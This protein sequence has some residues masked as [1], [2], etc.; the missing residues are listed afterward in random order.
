MMDRGF[1]LAFGVLLTVILAA[2]CVDTSPLPYTPNAKDASSDVTALDGS[3]ERICE[4]CIEQEPTCSYSNC[5]ANP[6][7]LAF[8]QC[9]MDLGC[10]VYPDLQPDRLDCGQPCLQKAGILDYTNPVVGLYLP[11]NACTS[12]GNPCASVCVTK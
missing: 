11:V 7:C 8:H 10:L 1:H 3:W 4:A 2:S 9:V 12:P 6:Q 5:Q